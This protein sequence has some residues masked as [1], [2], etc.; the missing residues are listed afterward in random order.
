MKLISLVSLCSLCV[1]TAF[2][3]QTWIVDASNGPGSHFTGLPSAVAAASDGDTLQVRA[4]SYAVFSTSKALR[5][6]GSP[7]AQFNP[8]ILGSFPGTV[9]IHD[10]PA[11]RTFLMKG[12]SFPPVWYQLV[13]LIHLRNNKGHVHF[14]Y[15]SI[16]TG[17]FS[18]GLEIDSCS[19]VSW[20]HS[21]WNSRVR[22]LDSTVVCSEVSAHN[23][24]MAGANP[25][26]ISAVRCD[27]LVSASQFRGVTGSRSTPFVLY[28][29]PALHLIDSVA[30]F[31]AETSL[32]AGLKGP[33]GPAAPGAVI[34]TG[35]KID[36][37]SRVAITGGIVSN[38]PVTTRSIPGL[39]VNGGGPG[40]IL[41]ATHYGTPG[42]SAWILIA[43]PGPLVT[44]PIGFDVVGLDPA[45]LIVAGGGVVA[46]NRQ[47][48]VQVSVP[49]NPLIDGTPIAT[50]GVEFTAAGGL[51][52][53]LPVTVV[54]H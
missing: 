11:G 31:G 44:M 6:L 46:A 53:T 5:V 13:P 7:G 43:N 24:G 52:L 23:L 12:I 41:A 45:S 40:A 37:D 35:S 27:L 16:A 54:L 20:S 4:G 2:A 42:S 10:L 28:A 21:T 36:V 49:S 29:G 15:V 22:F 3:Q 34:A 50:Q 33:L 19:Q 14:D 39:R 25:P 38:R 9:L 51:L 32:I 26:V 47:F 17:P 48:G 18:L 1:S 8:G 30:T